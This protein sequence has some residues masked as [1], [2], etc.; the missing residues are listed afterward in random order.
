MSNG[1]KKLMAS[2][3][4]VSVPTI[5]EHLKNIFANGEL[6]QEAVIRK[7][8]ITAADGKNYAT[9]FYNLDAIIS[10]GYRVNTAAPNLN[11]VSTTF[12]PLLLQ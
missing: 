6:V 9:Q 8:R 12:S 11:C 7:F 1:D 2:L 3:F 4:D 10:V 5:N